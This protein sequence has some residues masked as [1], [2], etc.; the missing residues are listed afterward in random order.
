MLFLIGSF[1]IAHFLSISATFKKFISSEQ[2]WPYTATR[3]PGNDHF[4]SFPLV[5]VLHRFVCSIRPWSQ[6]L[7]PTNVVGTQDKFGYCRGLVNR[8]SDN[9]CPAV[10]FSQVQSNSNLTNILPSLLQ[11]NAFISKEPLTFANAS[12]V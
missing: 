5:A 2:R 12:S 1:N 4:C 10:L 6:T 3:N 9:Q 7:L 11:L 8:K